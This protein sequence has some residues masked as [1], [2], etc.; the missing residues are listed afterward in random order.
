MTRFRKGDKVFVLG[1]TSGD[2][3]SCGRTAPRSA[4]VAEDQVEGSL[5]VVLADMAW[6]DWCV[7]KCAKRLCLAKYVYRSKA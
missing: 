7:S 2:F 1:T 5:F 4:V 6:L 3:G